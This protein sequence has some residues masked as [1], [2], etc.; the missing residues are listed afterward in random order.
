M[1]LTWMSWK[2]LAAFLKDHLNWEW[3]PDFS[4]IVRKITG[5]FT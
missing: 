5:R 1:K 2:R 3:K 4:P